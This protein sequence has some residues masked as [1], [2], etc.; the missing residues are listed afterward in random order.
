M[1]KYTIGLDYGSDSV[2]AVLIDT[3]NGAEL[4]TEV[5]WYKRWK[6]NLHH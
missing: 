2:R 1:K 4:A 6:K 3:N 5:H